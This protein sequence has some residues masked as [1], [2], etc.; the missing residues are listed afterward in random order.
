VA[1]LTQTFHVRTREKDVEIPWN[2][3]QKLRGNLVGAGCHSAA[4]EFSDLDPGSTIVLD[5][6]GKQA[7][8]RVVVV[9][10][11]EGSDERANRLLELRNALRADL[12]QG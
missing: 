11:R 2:L 7:L 3:C 5:Q 12:H 10:I 8:L 9:M 6:A 1:K 4:R